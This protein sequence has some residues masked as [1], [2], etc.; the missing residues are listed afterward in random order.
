MGHIFAESKS[1]FLPGLL[2]MSER[3]L[4]SKVM[5]RDTYCRDDCPGANLRL[6]FL[7]DDTIVP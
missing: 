7:L 5:F 1:I 6:I 4:L 2:L 3:T